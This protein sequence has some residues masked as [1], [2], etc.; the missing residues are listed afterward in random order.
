[1]YK[2]H[3]GNN[4]TLVTVSYCN[5]YDDKLGFAFTIYQASFVYKWCKFCLPLWSLFGQ[6]G[7]FYLHLWNLLCYKWCKFCL[8]VWSKFCLPLWSKFR[9]P[10]W[11]KFRLPLWSKFCL[12]YEVCFVT[13]V[14]QVLFTN[15][16]S[17]F[18]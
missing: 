16:A 5:D 2:L 6:Q 4:E 18:Y 9:L 13:F 8:P 10:L 14:Q 7:M 3:Y 17:F 11:R 15:G 12:V 1:M